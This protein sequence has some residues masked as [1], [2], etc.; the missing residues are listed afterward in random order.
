MAGQ[1]VRV[2]PRPPGGGAVWQGPR[3]LL[4]PGDPGGR[5][6][7]LLARRTHLVEGS[8]NG[9]GNG[10]GQRLMASG[11]LATLPCA[12]LARQQEEAH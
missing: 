4:P 11:L 3:L 7:D 12:V 9:N 2:G 8:G 6:G 1:F 10:E 5:C